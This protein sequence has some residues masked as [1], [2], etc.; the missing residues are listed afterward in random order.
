MPQYMYRAVT[1]E[2]LVVKN[3]VESPSK[4]ILIKSLKDTDLSPIEVIQVGY[5]TRKKGGAVAKKKNVL[6]V[7][8]IMKTANS[9]T[10]NR[11]KE[12]KI[13]TY[14]KL[15]MMLSTQQKITNKDL[16]TF[17]E[18]FYLLKKANFN[19][20][21][22]LSTIIDSTENFT[23]RGV[24]EDILA[25]VE[26]GEYMYSTM[27][28]YANV[29]PYIYVNMIKVGELSG[30]LTESL[31]QATMYL[32]TSNDTSRK[33]RGIIIPNLIQFIA[34]FILL[35]VGTL[36]TVPSIQNVYQAVGSDEQ[37][38]AIT[39]KFTE[40]LKWV[41]A[42]W[43]IIVL[44]IGSSVALVIFYINTP[45][46]R[47]KFDYFKYTAPIF[48][49]LM[50]RIDFSRVMKAISLNIENGMRIQDALDICKNV[51]DNYVMR[52]MIETAINNILV[53][54]SW[55]EPFEKSGL[56]SNMT[57]EMLKVGMQ[58][59]LTEMMQKL[60]DYIAVEIDQTMANL[61]SVLPQVTYGI[62]GVFLIFVV[63][64]V[65]VPCINVYMGSFLF[66]AA[67]L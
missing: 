64:I 41:S 57:I 20:I 48:G 19:N 21:H 2:G 27:E 37:L 29:F 39:L 11:G 62:V 3:K 66:S 32:E 13:S 31:K 51:V 58:T 10:I 54:E 56:G 6:D 65:L 44:I 7:E 24:L 23:F 9:A 67:G 17:T 45:R 53:G 12:K 43:Y 63:I 1:K 4:N 50:Y 30:S 34:L 55:I 42:H 47:Y 8:E 61:M 59:N 18:N 28:Y 5:T 14:E 33:L 49:K 35:F 25:G 22:A 16:K 15:N 52:A 36:Y 26:A 46:G 40:F 38:P 60:L